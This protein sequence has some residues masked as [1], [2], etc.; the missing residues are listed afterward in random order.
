[1]RDFLL[2]SRFPSY[3]QTIFH[4]YLVRGVFYISVFI[5]SLTLLTFF[6]L[7][8]EMIW[9]PKELMISRVEIIQTCERRS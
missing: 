6:L 4:H 9:K 1:M 5:F 3:V 7:M 2:D 8:G